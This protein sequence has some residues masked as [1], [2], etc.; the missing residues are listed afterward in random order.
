MEAERTSEPNGYTKNHQKFGERRRKSVILRPRIDYLVAPEDA[1]NARIGNNGT[2]GHR[3]HAS[4]DPAAALN[5]VGMTGAANF[6]M[7]P[8]QEIVPSM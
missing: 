5:E 6:M 1:T 3:F 2:D 7:P 4:N 8:Q